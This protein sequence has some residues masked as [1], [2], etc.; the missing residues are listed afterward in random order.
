[1]FLLIQRTFCNFLIWLNFVTAPL[2]LS[3]YIIFKV[4]EAS[5]PRI[6]NTQAFDSIAEPFSSNG[7]GRFGT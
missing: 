4:N 3:Q 2:I 1:M 5:N 7:V 6:V